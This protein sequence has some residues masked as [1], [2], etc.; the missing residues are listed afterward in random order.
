MAKCIFLFLFLILAPAARAAEGVQVNATVDR[1]QVGTGDVINLLVSVSAQDSIQVNPPALPPLKGF[2]LINTSTG[3]ETRSTFQNGRFLTQQ[4][5]NF[6]YMLAITEKGTLTIPEIT[7][8]V[9]GKSYKTQSIKVSATGARS[10][11][12]V[13]Q[14]G[15]QQRGMDP[16]EEMDNM[17]EIFNQMLQRRLAPRFHGQNPGMGQV[18]PPANPEEAFHIMAEVDKT[19]AY[20]GEQV[21]V[22]YWLYTRGQIRDIDTLKYPDLRGFWKEEIEMATRLNFEQVVLSGIVYQR[23]LLVSY[24]LFPIKAGKATIDPYRAKCTVVTASNLGFGRP[25]VFTKASKPIEIEVVDVPAEGRPA[26]YSGAVGNFRVTAQFEPPTAAVNSP[27]T[28]RVRF[29]GNGNA[30]LIE[31]PKL[32]LPPSMELYDQKN[33]AK[34]AKDGSS[35][36]EFEVMIIPREPGVFQVPAVATTMFDPQSRK[37]TPLSSQPLSLTVMG[38]A[39]TPAQPSLTATPAV[40]QQQ[41]QSELPDLSNAVD[42]GEGSQRVLNILAVLAFLAA[43]G[44]MGFGAWSSLRRR[45]KRASLSAILMR[46]LKL[47]REF[48][49]KGDWRRVGVELTNTLY[50]ILGQ[51]SDQGGANVDLERLLESTPPSLRAELSEP[52]RKLVEKCEALSFAPEKMVGDLA[53]K[54]KLVALIDESEK[55]MSRMLELAEL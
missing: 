6:N 7:V 38:T 14:R 47:V 21:T 52:I 19:K 39:T 24:A 8:T 13:A 37:F 40:P 33:N 54:P 26:N 15:Q 46:R 53:E 48:A 20:V 29:E 55:V 16:F 22:N 51:I 30:K 2:E 34:F 10:A 18:T 35:Y 28:L 3:V 44:V 32:D 17:E 1:N 27:V 45:P 36:K 4:S 23:A 31:L 9:D 49:N 11:P 5:R 50:Y 25:Y 42:A 12:N 41:A 43:F